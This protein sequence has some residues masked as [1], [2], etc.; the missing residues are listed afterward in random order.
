MLP[1]QCALRVRLARR[2]VAALRWER[3]RRGRDREGAVLVLQRQW[4]AVVARREAHQL[5]AGAIAFGRAVLALACTLQRVWRGHMGR[6]RAQWMRLVGYPLLRARQNFAAVR[7]QCCWR[8][9]LGRLLAQR[10]RAQIELEI[11]SARQ[12][13]RVWKGYRTPD[14]REA[15]VMLLA[16]KM[17]EEADERAKQ[18]QRRARKQREAK[19]VQAEGRD[20]ASECG[21]EDDWAPA[22]MDPSGL[23]V[24]SW[25]SPS[26]QVLAAAPTDWALERSLVGSTVRLPLRGN[27][28][29]GGLRA[30]R[31]QRWVPIRRK[32]KLLFARGGSRWVDLHAAAAGVLVLWD[33]AAQSPAALVGMEGWGAEPDLAHQEDS[34]SSEGEG[35]GDGGGGEPDCS[36]P[37]GCVWTPFAQL[38]H[39]AWGAGGKEAGK[40][41]QGGVGGQASAGVAQGYGGEDWQ[42]QQYYPGVG[43]G[44][45]GQGA[46]AG[47]VGGYGYGYEGYGGAGAG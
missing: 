45:Y 30:A 8:G 17:R 47:D 13:Q 46:A 23:R 29:G 4:R 34:S 26:R 3:E 36:P 1:L 39:K 5:R 32:F 33:S 22:E 2:K 16:Q 18:A 40:S 44:G 28:G 41:Q 19:K 38:P 27:K 21:S 12:I 25:W 15:A 14:W 24:A 20:S 42:G 7:A 11:R 9:Y 43:A 10:R 37:E 6:R 31:V 35:G